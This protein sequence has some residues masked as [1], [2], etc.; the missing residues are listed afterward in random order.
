MGLGLGLGLGFGLGLGSGFGLGL[1]LGL[2]FAEQ[3]A[4][5]EQR[6]DHVEG[7]EQHEGT[8]EEVAEDERAPASGYGKG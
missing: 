5:G 7:A 3:E 1:G 8:A 4:H 2:G 6:R